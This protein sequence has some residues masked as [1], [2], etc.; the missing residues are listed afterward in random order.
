MSEI[1]DSS[2]HPASHY[3]RVHS[4]WTLIMGTEFHYGFFQEPDAPL[5][6]A[7]A[8]LTSL[9]VANAEITAGDDVLDVGCGTGQPACQMAS[10]YGAHV[11]GITTSA[12]G[13]TRA[14]ELAKERG[15]H[16]ARFE[17]RD[18]TDTG[19]PDESF[20]VAWVLESSHLMR[21]RRALLSECT[22]VLR[23]GGRLALCDIIRQRDI[24]FDEIRS[25]RK[26]FATL[27]AAFGDAHMEPLDHYAVMLEQLGMIVTQFRDIT[28]E[29]MPTFAAWRAN[30][31]A[32][33]GQL[34]PLLAEEEIAQFV[35]STEILESFWMDGTLGYGLIAARKPALNQLPDRQDERILT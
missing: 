31:A 22:R 6:Q 34:H 21:D 11:L 8:A 20:D 18:G 10:R 25:R 13:V 23:P 28:A 35:R 19:L 7:T 1:G 26:E 29:T 24:G 27:R 17:L 4:A 12:E 5:S 33:E 9:M 15:I 16:D 2:H 14:T 32:H 3:D 30:V